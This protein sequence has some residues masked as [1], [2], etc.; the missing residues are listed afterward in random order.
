MCT[1][2]CVSIWQLIILFPLKKM[3]LVP[4][5]KQLSHIML[6]IQ[7][8]IHSEHQWTTWVWKWPF[9]PL[10]KCTNCHREHDLN[11]CIK[12]WRSYQ[13]KKPLVTCDIFH[14][15]L[16]IVSLRWPS[17]NSNFD[18]PP[19]LKWR[20]NVAWCHTRSLY[21]SGLLSSSHIFTYLHILNS[22][23]W[24]QSLLTPA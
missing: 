24:S 7:D 6:K 20:L 11:L 22:N 21:L 8:E 18:N 1:H 13:P 17:S 2:D 10:P 3:I 19:G 4:S 9:L 16:R 15:S 23:R 5:L 14:P 12:F